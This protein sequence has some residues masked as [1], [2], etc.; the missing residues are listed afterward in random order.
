LVGSYLCVSPTDGRIALQN[1]GPTG[2]RIL[3][4]DPAGFKLQTLFQ[5]PP[6]HYVADLQWYSDPVRGRS[7]V[8]LSYGTVPEPYASYLADLTGGPLEFVPDL[9][10]PFDRISPDGKRFLTSGVAAG[11][12]VVNVFVR[13]L[14][15]PFGRP[16]VQVTWWNPP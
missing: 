13:D 11:D 14:A 5:A 3:L 6:L 8:A 9:L 10:G 4:A 2:Q 12:S 1:V 7:A 16:P 15:D